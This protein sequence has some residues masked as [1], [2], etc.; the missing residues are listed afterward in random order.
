MEWNRDLNLDV[1]DIR[2]SE[3]VWQDKPDRAKNTV[4]FDAMRKGNYRPLHGYP[5][6]KIC[7]KENHYQVLE[8]STK[9][10]AQDPGQLGHG[11]GHG[12]N[13]RKLVQIRNLGQLDVHLNFFGKW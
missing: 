5:N 10:G 8:L 2:E 1:A 11:I 12:R 4:S 7:K 9:P 6:S 13:W 3:L